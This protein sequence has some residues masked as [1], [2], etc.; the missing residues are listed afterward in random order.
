MGETDAKTLSKQSDIPRQ[1][2]YRGLTE[3]QENGFV[4]KIIST[5]SRYRAISFRELLSTIQNEK[6]NQYDRFSKRIQF[7]LE[8]IEENK[9]EQEA[10]EDFEI[11]IIEGKERVINRCRKS[12]GSAQRSV[13][14]CSIFQRWIQ[15]GQEIH[16]TIQEAVLRGVQYR[17]ILESPTNEI[18]IPKNVLSLMEKDNF[19]VR[20]TNK[21][22]KI[23]TVIFDDT[24]AGFSLY[25]SKSVVETPMIWTNHPSIIESFRGYFDSLWSEKENMVLDSRTLSQV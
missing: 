18:K 4:D 12:H 24:L 20:I 21:Q 13:C 23:N 8:R 9:T 15:I 5:P 14:C 16:D 19:Q 11:S 7:F 17:M 3:L 1:E 10:K 6:T 25:P 2:I 22:L